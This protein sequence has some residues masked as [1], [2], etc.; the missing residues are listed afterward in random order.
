[1]PKLKLVTTS[2]RSEAMLHEQRWMYKMVRYEEG[3]VGMVI[4]LS[5]DGSRLCIRRESI[6]GRTNETLIV[7]KDAPDVE[8]IDTTKKDC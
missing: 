2:E 5:R 7:W 3:R 6:R 8:L 4:D 1:M